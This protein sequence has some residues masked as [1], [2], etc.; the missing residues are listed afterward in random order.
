[1]KKIYRI[2]EFSNLNEGI[3]SSI[4]SGL[5]KLLGGKRGKIEELLKSIKSAKMEEVKE[6]VE[7]EKELAKYSKS[8]SIENKFQIQNLNRQLRTIRSL[9][10]REIGS[11]NRQIEKITKDDPKLIAFVSSELAKIQVEATQEMIKK[12]S[13]YK[14]QDSLQLLNR[15][16]D[17]LVKSATQ[18]E[19][20]FEREIK[21]EAF[22][23]PKIEAD[24]DVISFVDLDSQNAALYLKNLPDSELDNLHKGLTNWRIDLEVETQNQISDIRKEIKKSEK[25]GASW[26]VPQ[27]E[28]ELLRITYMSKKPIDKIRA[29]IQTVEKEMKI[30]R[31]GIA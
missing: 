9:K 5:S 11:Y 27:L 1:V 25:E 24:S 16:F 19:K 12:V 14:D 4:S 6:V 28:A 26:V 18:R 2:N 7:I 13:P 23:Q 20:E 17:S 31:Y 21:D 22:L 8:D 10:E 3:L 15:E 29:K 30:R